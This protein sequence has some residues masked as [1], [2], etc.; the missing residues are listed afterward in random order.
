MKKIIA[1]LSILSLSLL[2]SCNSNE[3]VEEENTNTGEVNV[4]ME[5]VESNEEANLEE[6]VNSEDETAEEETNSEE[7]VSED[8]N[9]EANVEASVD[10]EE[11]V[12]ELTK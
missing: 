6:E 4:E 12:N 11:E 5:N 10:V 8:E 2:A 7:E 3:V 9:V 1:L